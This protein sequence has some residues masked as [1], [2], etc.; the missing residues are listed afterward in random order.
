MSHTSP[1]LSLLWL[2]FIT[3]K[4]KS[5]EVRRIFYHA[6]TSFSFLT[7]SSR[8]FTNKNAQTIGPRIPNNTYFL[9]SWRNRWCEA[10]LIQPGAFVLRSVGNPQTARFVVRTVFHI[11]P[12]QCTCGEAVLIRICYTV[13]Q[14]AFEEGIFFDRYLVSITFGMDAALRSNAIKIASHAAA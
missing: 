14:S 4:R 1:P 12:C 13:D 2:Y 5:K 7:C 3:I 9:T 10:S 8:L 11:F 6:R